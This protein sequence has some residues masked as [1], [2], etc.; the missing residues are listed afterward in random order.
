MFILTNVIFD[1]NVFPY[2]SRNKE[3]GPAPIPVEEED[4]I[5]D[6]IKDNTRRR[7]L[8]PSRDILVPI[9]LGLGYQPDQPCLLDNGHSSG[10]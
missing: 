6:L 7:N 5:N 10:P 1:E 3:D 9:P 4:L 8:E 2:Y